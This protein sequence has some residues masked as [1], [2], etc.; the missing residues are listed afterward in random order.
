MGRGERPILWCDVTVN[1]EEWLG[2][3]DN[4]EDEELLVPWLDMWW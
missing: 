4:D 1:C 2:W 3:A